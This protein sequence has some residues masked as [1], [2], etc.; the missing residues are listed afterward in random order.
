MDTRIK[1]QLVSKLE[2]LASDPT[3]AP[4]VKPIRENGPVFIVC[5]T[6]IS[7]SFTS[8]IAPAARSSSLTSVREEMFIGKA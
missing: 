8:M 3:H 4:G 2:E 5:G 7:G 1:A 6:A